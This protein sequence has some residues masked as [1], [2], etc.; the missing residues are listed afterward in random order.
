MCLLIY[1]EKEKKEKKRFLE[2]Y[3]A[4]FNENLTDTKALENVRLG[5]P[6]Y[7]T[8]INDLAY[9][10]EGKLFV[11]IEHQSTISE[12][13]ILR[14]LVYLILTIQKVL[15]APNWFA[16]KMKKFPKPV[17][18]V[19]YNGKENF[20]LESKLRLSDFF[21]EG[22]DEF[23]IDLVVKVININY[24]K[25]HKILEKSPI[26]KDYA[27]LVKMVN[28]K[29]FDKAIDECLELGVLKG[30]LEENIMEVKNMLKWEYDYDMDIAV[31]RAEAE[32]IGLEKGEAI[33]L[34]KGSYQK[35]IETAKNALKMGLSVDQISILTGLSTDEIEAL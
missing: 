9:L 30:Y 1:L 7:S 6:F 31:Q 12:L 8:V 15:K 19:F 22:S 3:N 27:F 10:V 5:T 28:E 14:V 29:G 11:F 18:F 17:F 26:L 32:A 23:S 21:I 35:A 4:L 20:P 25:G 24:D 13:I 33:G 34:E 2:L 16:R